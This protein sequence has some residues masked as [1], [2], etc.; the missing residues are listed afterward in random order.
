MAR[1][2][3]SSLSP[4]IPFF[5]LALWASFLNASS[6]SDLF[7]SIPESRTDEWSA[8]RRLSR[9]SYTPIRGS[10]ISMRGLTEIASSGGIRSGSASMRQTKLPHGVRA[11]IDNSAQ[12][13]ASAS[14]PPP[15]NIGYHWDD[16]SAA[17]MCSANAKYCGVMHEP[18]AVYLVWYGVFTE[19]QKQIMRTFIESLN[20]GNSNDTSL[21]VPKW[22]NINRLYYDAQGNNI[23]GSVTLKGEIDDTLYSKGT[24]LYNS[25]VA[26]LI[27]SA[28]NDGKLPNDSNGVY[29]VLGDS[30]VAQEDD[31]SYSQSGFCSSYCGWHAYTHDNLELVISFVGNAVTRCPEGCIPPYLNQPGAVAPNGDAGMDGM[32]SVVAH[33][34]AEATSSP[35]L[36]TWFNDQGEENADIC[37]GDYG[38]VTRDATTGAYFNLEGVRGSKFI[39]QANL[40]PVTGRCV[41]QSDGPEALGSPSEPPS[42]AGTTPSPPPA[43]EPPVTVPTPP[44]TVPTPPET[45]PEPPTVATPEPPVTGTP[46]GGS[47]WDALVSFLSSLFGF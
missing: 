21:T 2:R 10:H 27:S 7:P 40:D 32:V 3:L 4:A 46:S 36:A 41:V 14:N 42:S 18:I 34:L 38:D 31:S 43:S 17:Y 28:V 23:S 13:G 45:V 44:V 19:A 47:T 24:T 33:E 26:D 5:F 16:P 39:V 6:A 12:V 11:L 22:W 20:T 37:A 35:F 29:F 8:M 15:K 9:I 1:S 25:G 30:K